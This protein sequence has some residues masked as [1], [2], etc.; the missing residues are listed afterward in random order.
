W[1]NGAAA[2]E[3]GDLA[4]LI[5]RH[6]LASTRPYFLPALLR[7]TEQALAE[8]M[9]ASPADAPVIDAIFRVAG[10]EGVRDLIQLYAAHLLEQTAQGA[11]GGLPD[12][13]A[14]VNLHERPGPSPSAP[15]ERFEIWCPGYD[16]SKAFFGHCQRAARSLLDQG[17]LE[18]IPSLAEEAA[19]LP[20]SLVQHLTTYVGRLGERG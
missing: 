12:I 14:F 4:A 7:A 11:P 3:S 20:P 15:V 2:Q 16:L 6:F 1:L 13:L 10:S 18:R 17:A 19:Q 5:E 9:A 8:F